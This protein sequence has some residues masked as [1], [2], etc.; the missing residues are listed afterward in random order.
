MDIVQLP[1]IGIA[2][3]ADMDAHLT[4]APPRWRRTPVPRR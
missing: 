2:S 4:I 3:I 1:G